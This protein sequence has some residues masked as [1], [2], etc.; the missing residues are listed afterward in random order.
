MKY[1]ELGDTVEDVISGFKGVAIAR[2]TWITGCNRII[3]QPLFD[4]KKQELPETMQ[5]DEPM[6]KIVARAK[7]S[8]KERRDHSGTEPVTEITTTGGP[9]IIPMKPR[10]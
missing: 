7:K 3:V 10:A 5:F 1:I 6:L 2:T 9:A 4:A 8:I